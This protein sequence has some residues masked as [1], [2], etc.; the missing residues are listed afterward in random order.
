M[1]DNNRMFSF[2]QLNTHA[3]QASW[4]FI[5]LLAYTVGLKTYEIVYF[6]RND[7]K[8]VHD[9]CG[10]SLDVLSFHLIFALI[11]LITFL[12]LNYALNTGDSKK[13]FRVLVV[14][15]IGIFVKGV[16]LI[17]DYVKGIRYW[18]DFLLSI[19]ILASA[20]YLFTVIRGVY[21]MFHR[22]ESRQPET[23]E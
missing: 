22:N 19:V 12:Y 18:P 21:H 3:H 17:H 7:C 13:I 16:S 6:I 11:H 23:K 2:L 15:I 5:S 10:T 14:V 4:V 8:N 20:I 9:H 1:A